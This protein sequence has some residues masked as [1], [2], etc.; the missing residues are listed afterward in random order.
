MKRFLAFIFI[1]FLVTSCNGFFEKL[2][3]LSYDKG[4]ER[5]IKNIEKPFNGIII[6]TFSYRKNL[7][8]TDIVLSSGDSIFPTNDQ[9]MN[10]VQIGDSIYKKKSDNYLY[11]SSRNSNQIE[12]LWF[13]KIPQKYRDDEDFPEEWRT[14]WMESTVKD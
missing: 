1:S 4:R 6:D 2:D 12:K 14:K 10:V 7:K 9:V 3:E 13:L 8:A 5:L 11:I